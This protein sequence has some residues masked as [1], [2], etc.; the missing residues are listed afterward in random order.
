MHSNM[1]IPEY[2]PLAGVRVLLTGVA[3]SGPYAARWMGD[4]G[5]EV[6]KVEIPVSGDTSRI[7]PRLSNGSVPKWL[8]LGRNMNSF[9]FNMNFTK[10]PASKEVFVDLIKQCDIWINSVP[11]IGKH[12]P[13]DALC[14][15]ANPK[16]VIVHI[17]GYG[18]E[19]S[20]GVAPYLGK[21]CVD[22]VGQAFSGL[23]AMQGMPDGPYLTANP[24][25]CDITTSLVA[26]SGAL[27][28]YSNALKTG[29][30]QVVDASMYE[31]AGLL[32]NYQWC[33][34]LNMKRPYK[35]SGPLN[36]LW[37][38]FGYYKCADGEWVSVGVWGLG[39]WKKF[40]DLMGVTAEDFPYMSTCGQENPEL[41]KKM[42]DI[43]YAWLA[44][45][46]ASEVEKIF[47]E[48][49]I[50]VSKINSAQ[51]AFENPHWQARGDFITMTDPTTG[52]DV[53]D[54]A[55]VPRFLG[56]PANVYKAGPVLGSSTDDV[57]S[58][59]LGYSA[60]KINELKEAKAVAASLTT[61]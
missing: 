39:I 48:I 41:V 38:P 20:G 44:E 21:P 56:T 59:I 16:L 51:D 23:A 28:A 32:M 24:L 10:S 14:M 60:E 5:A 45:H 30:G 26:V 55:T 31:S 52:E 43:W 36:P 50:P 12:G 57:L 46:T 53:I 29:K 37:K 13:N 35:R 11:N 47:M 49:G 6:I 2:G 25:V 19:E 18:L 7:G 61:K 8:S 40:C 33:E 15:E 4:M 58:K 54:F 42:E 17:S 3:F 27:A 22:P 34:Q 9:E 1:L